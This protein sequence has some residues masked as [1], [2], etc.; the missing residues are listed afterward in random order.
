MAGPINLEEERLRRI[1]LAAERETAEEEEEFE[2]GVDL[3]IDAMVAAKLSLPSM[4]TAA[5]VAMIDLLEI[6]G[7][8]RADAIKTIAEK[9]GFFQKVNKSG[10][11]FKMLNKKKTPTSGGQQ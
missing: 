6:N 1:R 8:S 4:L 5:C 2:A 7:Y 9:I 10:G 3:I 11:L